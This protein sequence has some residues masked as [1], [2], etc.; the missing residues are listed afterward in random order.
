MADKDVFIIIVEVRVRK[1]SVFVVSS[2]LDMVNFIWLE[3]SFI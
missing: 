3:N 1:R 2:R